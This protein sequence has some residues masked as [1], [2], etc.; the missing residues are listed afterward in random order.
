EAR[1]R[2]A[3]LVARHDE[4]ARHRL[5]L[6]ADAAAEPR[7]A[8]DRRRLSLRVHVIRLRPVLG[9]RLAG[10]RGRVEEPLVRGEAGPRLR[11]REGAVPLA[12]AE[13]RDRAAVVVDEAHRE[14]PVGA[15]D[16]DRREAPLAVPRPELLRDRGELRQT[17]RRL[18]LDL[19]VQVGPVR[20][21]AR[22][23]VVRHAVE[24]AVVGRRGG[25]PGQPVCASTWS[26]TVILLADA[27]VGESVR[28][29][30]VETATRAATSAKLATKRAFIDGPP[31]SRWTA[32]ASSSP[33]CGRTGVVRC[34]RQVVHTSWPRRGHSHIPVAVVKTNLH[35]P[36]AT[37]ARGRCISTP[38]ER[39]VTIR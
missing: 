32:Y 5:V 18:R 3:G 37:R 39:S 9:A 17:L 2:L 23:G 35:R 20:D 33:S 38:P 29:A 26:Q 19:L 10:T 1:H 36:R 30:A 31:R 4:L 22:P 24:L 14:V 25:D 12:V 11:R 34:G 6:L 8:D 27:R 7:R 16:V 15:R 13:R 28:A 21:H